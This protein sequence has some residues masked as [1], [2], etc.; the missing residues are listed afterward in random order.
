[1]GVSFKGYTELAKW[2]LENG[3]DINLKHGNGGTA[4]MFATM[5]GRNQVVRVL[6]EY[7]ADLT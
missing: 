1:M 5:F 2:L 7:G 6:L 3:A 4:L